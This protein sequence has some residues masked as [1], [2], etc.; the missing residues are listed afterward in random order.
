MYFIQ[1]VLLGIN[2]NNKTPLVW[3]LFRDINAYKIIKNNTEQNS[4]LVEIE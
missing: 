4:S 1:K 3:K 2:S